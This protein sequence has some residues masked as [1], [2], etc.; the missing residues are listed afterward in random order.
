VAAVARIA[1]AAGC[2]RAFTCRASAGTLCFAPGGADQPGSASLTA[3]FWFVCMAK[4]SN[5][6]RLL[7]LLVS[8][9]YLDMT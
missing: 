8:S 2:C 3:P 6:L 4:E 7:T 1:S 9:Y 5:E